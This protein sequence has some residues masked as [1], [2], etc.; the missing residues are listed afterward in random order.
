MLY[1]Y[2]TYEYAK[3]RNHHKSTF[4]KTQH[5]PSVSVQYTNIPIPADIGR[6]VTPYARLGSFRA[7]LPNLFCTHT[8][9]L[10]LAVSDICQPSTT[11]FVCESQTTPLVCS[12]GR[13]AICCILEQ[14]HLLVDCNSRIVPPAVNNT[15]FPLVALAV[16]VYLVLASSS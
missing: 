6:A 11:P 14:P 10:I 2:P 15:T 5:Q 7:K 12:N 16:T 13:T 8:Y 4:L 1:V 3:T 9:L